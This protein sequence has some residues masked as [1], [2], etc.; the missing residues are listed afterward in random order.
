M[1]TVVI[2]QD[3]SM[4]GRL[5]Q[6]FPGFPG[7]V[8]RWF[9]LFS[10]SVHTYRSPIPFLSVPYNP[11]PCKNCLFV[12]LT[13]IPASL[14]P[15]CLS[16]LLPVLSPGRPLSPSAGGLQFLRCSWSFL[17]CFSFCFSS[18]S[19]AFLSFSAAVWMSLMRRFR[20][21]RSEELS[22]PRLCRGQGKKSG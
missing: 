15:L 22:T 16:R 3:F 11:G 20:A 12:V 9:V 17:L 18:L 4:S 6:R 5:H 2:F 19:R 8:E 10:L 14:P 13:C 1:I 7:R 21:L